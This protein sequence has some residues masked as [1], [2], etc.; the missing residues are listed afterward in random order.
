MD[1]L[2]TPA[3][4]KAVNHGHSVFAPSSSAMHSTCAASLL[5]NFGKADHGSID[6]AAG[7]VGHELGEKWLKA[8]VEHRE[9][10]KDEFRDHI[11]AFVEL[12]DEAI[13]QFEPVDRIGERVRVPKG[14]GSDEHYTV[15]I[16]EDMIAHVRRYV[17]W[18]INL[19]GD[20]YVETRIDISELTPI[21]GQGGT[22]DH[23]VISA[24][25]NGG[26]R[27][28]ITDLKMGRGEAI[29]P[30]EYP[31]D[32]R[33]IIADRPNGNTQ[34]MDYAFGF[35]RLY[36][37]LFSPDDE[38]VIRI[39][40]PPRDY[41]GEWHT[42]V[43][44]LIENF[45]PWIK[46]RYR[47]NWVLGQ[48]RTASIKGCRW[49]KV[50]A[51]CQSWLVLYDT[52]SDDVF[53]PADGFTIEGEFR[54]VTSSEIVSAGASIHNKVLGKAVM[55]A[56]GEVTT[57]QL[58]LIKLW[59]K[60]FEHYFADVDIE[61]L[62]RAKDGEELKYFKLIPGRLGKREPKEDMAEIAVDIV[63]LTEEEI[64]VK[65]LKTPVELTDLVRH[66]YKVTKKVAEQIVSALVTRR[67]GQDTLAS[68]KDERD[69]LEDIGSVFDSVED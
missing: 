52:L 5:E 40:Q 50:K 57:E 34:A 13:S 4:I 18:C 30:A 28:T 9:Q 27:L 25:A 36:G 45:A 23:A 22:A 12:D 47:K 29:Y 42:T 17:A 31:D 51:T 67:D 6:A 2:P 37:D 49:C 16:T 24:T 56:P 15:T 38:V 11:D 33:A 48:P 69:E 43:A 21:P 59:R 44:E 64:Y 62:R 53:D 35:V 14:G 63:G 66:K 46:K 54:E 61:L 58:E 32:E 19:P 65:V 41:F 10:L 60:S 39:A 20:H 7:T 1:H 55:A 26:M 8:L 68:R 3:E